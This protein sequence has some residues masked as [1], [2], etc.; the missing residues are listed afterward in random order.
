MRAKDGGSPP[1]T[2]TTVVQVDVDRNLNKPQFDPQTY[3]ARVLETLPLGSVVATVVAKDSDL[4][5]SY[6]LNY[7][8]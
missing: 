7:V 4:R 6:I 2:D 1:R 8:I 5:V 3:A